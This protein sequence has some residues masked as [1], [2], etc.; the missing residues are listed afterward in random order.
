MN[1]VFTFMTAD[2]IQENYHNRSYIIRLIFTVPK[3][4]NAEENTRNCE[5]VWSFTGLNITTPLHISVNYYHNEKQELVR[6]VKPKVA[7]RL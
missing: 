7:N 1:T 2:T 5:S 4:T 6:K 3:H